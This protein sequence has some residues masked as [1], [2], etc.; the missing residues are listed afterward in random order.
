MAFNRVS[1]QEPGGEGPVDVLVVDARS[2]VREPVAE[3]LRGAGFRVEEA[4]DGADVLAHIRSTSTGALVF[5]RPLSATGDAD[6]LV[7]LGKVGSPPVVVLCESPPRAAAGTDGQLPLGGTG[8]PATESKL[9]MYLTGVAFEAGGW[10]EPPRIA[11][12]R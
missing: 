7:E 10:H 3:A 5:A 11:A 9:L 2:E 4:A 12:G 8:V 1:Q 6:L